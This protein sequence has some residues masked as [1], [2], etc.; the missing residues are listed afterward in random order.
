MIAFFTN[1]LA[2][3]F[4]LLALIALFLVGVGY[5][6]YSHR[7]QLEGEAE[8]FYNNAKT[9]FEA[10]ETK[11]KTQLQAAEQ[12]VEDRF[13]RKVPGISGDSAVGSQ[14]NGQS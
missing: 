12:S 2:L 14:G 3:A 7:T 13:R 11:A 4:G 8:G 5:Y 1:H 10:A 6:L 9:R